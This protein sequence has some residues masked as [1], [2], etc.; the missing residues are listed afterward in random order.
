[1]T[2]ATRF[3]RFLLWATLI[4]AVLLAMM[5]TAL[6]IF[7]PNLNQ[8]RDEIE[9][10]LFQ[11]TGVHL[12]IE[13]MKG[14]WNNLTPSLAIKDTQVL[15]SDESHPILTVGRADAE[16]DLLASLVHL[17]P[18][19][20]NV[21]IQDLHADVSRWPLI[22][23]SSA[24]A[25]LNNKD[26]S[27]SLEAL[28]NLQNVFLKQLGS[29]SLLNSDIEY[30]APN[31]DIR[32]LEIERL[33]WKNDG[34]KHKAEGL[35]SIAG[36]N[37]NK[38][39]IIANFT[40][41]GD[42]RFIDGDF[43]VSG[44][45]IRV[46]PWIPQKF[47]DV[48]TIQSGR[49][50]LNA[51]FSLK[52]GQPTDALVELLPSH[53]I[54]G[55][56]EKQHQL[57]ISHA[58]VKLKPKDK[59]WQIHAQQFDIETDQ[60]DWSEFDFSIDFQSDNQ[61]IN[62][63]QL[64]IGNLTPLIEVSA[65]Q[66]NVIDVLKKAEPKG[67]IQDIRI[68]LPKD[69][70]Q[71][72]YSASLVDAGMNQFS[73]LPEVHNLSADITGNLTTASIKARLKGDNLPYGEVFQAP[74][75]IDNSEVNLVWQSYDQ[76]WKIWA[77]KINLETPDLSTIGEF[78][79]DFPNDQSPFLSIYAEA[80]VH[81]AGETWRYL[82][83]LALGRDLTDYLSAAIQGG[84]AKTAKILWYGALDDFPYHNH[85]GI[86]QVTVG[87]QDARFSFDTAWP[88]ITDLQLDL[89]FENDAM[90]LD[91]RSATLMDMHVQHISGEIPDLANSGFIDIKAKARAE[92][93]A[94]RDYMMATPLIDSVGAALTAVK[95][96]GPVESEFSIKVPFNSHDEVK[97][98]GFAQ[99]LDNPIEVQSPPVQLDHAKGRINFNND[100]VKGSAIK[101]NLLDQPIT[102]DFTSQNQGKN[103]GVNIDVVGDADFAK[104]KKQFPS[105]WFDP[106]AGHA[107]WNL[108]VDIQ[109]NDVGF[110]Y[111][112]DGS[113]DLE[114]LSSSYP[115]PLGKG[116]GNKSNAR[117]QAAGNQEL[118]NTRI[119][120]PE[121]KYQADV[122]IRPQV[123]LITA[124]NLIVG[125]GEFKVSPIGGHFA[126]ITRGKFDAD[127]WLSFIF[128]GE[129]TMN[130]QSTTSTSTQKVPSALS[131]PAIPMPEVVNI[132]TK[133]LLLCDLNWHNV[134]FSG[135]HKPNNW[136]MNVVSSEVVGSG[137]FSGEQ[138]LTLDLDSLHIFVPQ[139][140]DTQN[141]KLIK[142][143]NQEEPLISDFDREFHQ[144][145]PN[146]ALKIDDLW[147]QGYKVGSVD[148]QLER[149]QDKLVWKHLDFKTGTNHLKAS[150]WWGL[151]GDKSHSDF[152][153][154]LTGENNSDVMQRFGINS[155]IQ[156]ASFDIGINANWDGAP[157]SVKTNTLTGDLTT[158]F[159]DGVVTDVNGAA[160]LLGLFSLDSIIR[161]MQL[162]F[163]GVFDD[164][165]TFRSIKGTGKVEKGIFT[166]NNL[167]MDGSAGNL[168][169]RGKAD[170]NTQL[171]DANVTFIP[172]LT[173]SIPIVA[174][175][176]VTP[177]MAV[178][179][180][181]ITK[182]LTPM[183]DVF[184]K[185]EYEIKGP[186]DS[187][188]VKELS[189]SKGEFKPR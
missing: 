166:T 175:F 60:T 126:S 15:L 120:L 46:T 121:V 180:F 112:V 86:F 45:N 11:A 20:A 10:Q 34:Q 69:L 24:N 78:E 52:K 28:K 89:L 164:G 135:I 140:E 113:A 163:T 153:V 64:K 127:S 57:N 33:R 62:I 17:K 119:T 171:V 54:W 174:A 32:L 151:S 25:K 95:V 87:L 35:I 173:S 132:N 104:L 110:T 131:F 58:T 42:L 56:E 72:T 107:P 29:F 106:L 100:V 1:M 179:V 80:D 150:G 83:T 137:S 73:L 152:K 116:I 157:W 177:Q 143:L 77:D 122:D 19:L 167:K 147:L 3:W 7:L 27:S 170:L 144:Y 105:Q 22:P 13:D 184:T 90:Y 159:K 108:G 156:K 30:L 55:E 44:K 162:D 21:I 169:L 130:P 6:R 141:E 181:A 142:D 115:A 98:T 88:P 109:L 103:Y 146:L 161:K 67:L 125:Q 128:D 59:G 93:D 117:L 12:H 188:E 134:R 71:L 31:G 133:D 176:A 124:S 186:F 136:Q 23:N 99:L 149:D 189:R 183:I 118:L 92:G 63:S 2:L 96:S 48:T 38:I 81:N 85:K 39:S 82:P 75:V 51:W 61:I 114:Y 9:A 37:L 101:A 111:Q 41:N 50:S 53:L 160:R 70:D 172:D 185:I 123:P 165:M 65:K 43:F 18:K 178:A 129:H 49:V 145:M 139:W 84:Q 138:D 68:N 91:S 97:T 40:E 148:M 36:A 26:Q 168:E 154:N 5:V 102:L 158:E 187:P 14:Y 47:K 182:V 155:G 4:V 16:L 94:V 79:L 66:G 74:L 8:Y 76:G